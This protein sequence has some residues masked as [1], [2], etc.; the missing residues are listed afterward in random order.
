LPGLPEPSGSGPEREAHPDSRS[1]RA[2]TPRQP[3]KTGQNRPSAASASGKNPQRS[4]HGGEGESSPVWAPAEPPAVGGGSHPRSGQNRPNPAT[5]PPASP[6]L[7]APALGTLP[8]VLCPKTGKKRQKPAAPRRG[9][10]M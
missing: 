5:T 2:P 9:R 1:E 10:R 4:E 3:A 6:L 7:V 8:S